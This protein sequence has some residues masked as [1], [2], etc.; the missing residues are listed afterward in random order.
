M[1]INIILYYYGKSHLS[2][3]CCI[4]EAEKWDD[5]KITCDFL[6]VNFLNLFLIAWW[7]SVDGVIIVID[8]VTVTRNL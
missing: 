7:F 8:S 4:T 2:E 1:A 5:C 3:F 6:W